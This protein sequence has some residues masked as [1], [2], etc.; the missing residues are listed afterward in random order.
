MLEQA[1]F[2]NPRAV[3][4]AARV[5]T[6]VL[7]GA[8]TLGGCS[9]KGSGTPM[10]EEREL[11]A[12][13]EIELG[14]VFT[15]VVHV[16]PGTTQKVVVSGDDNIV[17]EILTKVSGG[18]LDLSIDHWMVRPDQPLEVEVWVASLTKIEASGASKIEVTG[19]HGENFELELSGASHS[20]LAGVVDR[21]ELDSSG[22]S[23]LDAKALQAKTVDVELSG[24][25]D[26]EVW[27]SETLDAEVSGA[28]KVRY[29]GEPATVNRDV[30][31]SGSVEPG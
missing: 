3:L 5:S 28:G 21:F 2:S 7:L 6:L 1:K 27:A 13:D 15:L 31:G 25:G 10:T 22:A 4:R 14:G 23:K 17:P 29:W 18:E 9:L 16:A 19:L 24:A 11:E 20:T 8:L 26:A 30:S 12:F